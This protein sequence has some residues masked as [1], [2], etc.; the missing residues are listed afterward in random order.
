MEAVVLTIHLILAISLVGIVLIQPSDG[1]Q[2][3]GIGGG[4]GGMTTARGAASF[5]TRLTAII[6]T[7]FMVT[8][9]TL[10]IMST[11]GHDDRSILERVET[12]APAAAVAEG[13]EEAADAVDDAVP[14]SE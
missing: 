14:I 11:R 12:S 1:N 3:G 7:A 13:A 9:M 10:A 2:L 4:M 6:V 5:L 8:S